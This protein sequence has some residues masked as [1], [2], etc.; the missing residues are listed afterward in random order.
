MFICFLRFETIGSVLI[1]GYPVSFSLPT[2]ADGT[3]FL[4]L[5]QA[6]FEFLWRIVMGELLTFE[7][8]WDYAAL[9]IFKLH[10]DMDRGVL[11]LGLDGLIVLPFCEMQGK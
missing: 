1:G 4:H 6:F 11:V 3:C 10:P 7:L 5:R 8:D 2:P 9:Y